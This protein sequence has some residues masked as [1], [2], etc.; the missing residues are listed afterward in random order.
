MIVWAE[1]IAEIHK[2]TLASAGPYASLHLAPDRQPHQHPTTQFF[3]GR[4]PFL[5]P[6]QPRRSTEGATTCTSLEQIEV[7]E[8]EGYSRPNL[9]IQPRRARRH[10]RNPHADRWWVCWLQ[11][12]ADD[13]LR[14]NFLSP[15]CRNYSRDPD[16][17]HLGAVSH[18]E[19][20]TSHGQP[21]YK[22]WSLYLHPLRRYEKRCK[23]QKLGRLEVTR[24]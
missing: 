1:Y 12:D 6:N 7:M 19:A 16:H 11:K 22:I 10:R 18:H 5:P 8:L 4:M 3:A 9:C 24:S 15:K 20:N 23:M 13:L 14:R 21:T 17:A 2:W